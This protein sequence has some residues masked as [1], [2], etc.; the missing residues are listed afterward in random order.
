M[1]MVANPWVIARLPSAAEEKKAR[2]ASRRAQRKAQFAA[3]YTRSYLRQGRVEPSPGRW[4]ERLQQEADDQRETIIAA[5]QAKPF[6][7]WYEVITGQPVSEFLADVLLG[8]AEF[9]TRFP[10]RSWEAEY[11]SWVKRKIEQVAASNPWKNP[12]LQAQWA[13]E[14][15]ECNCPKLRRQILQR[16]ATPAWANLEKIKAIYAE[17]DRIEEETG[18]PHEVD[19]IVP[20]VNRLVCGLHCE[21]NLRVIPTAENRSKSNKFDPDLAHSA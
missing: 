13:K 18:I 7:A 21:A 4:R 6:R 15:H 1:H 2:A 3:D 19:H 9:E 16:L 20:I 10:G 5:L 14:V 8:P 11:L 17:R 12:E